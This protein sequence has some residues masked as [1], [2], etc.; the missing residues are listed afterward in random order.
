MI[1]NPIRK[2]F[3]IMEICEKRNIKFVMFGGL[4]YFDYFSINKQVENQQ[5]P[6]KCAISPAEVV[7][8]LTNNSIFS[9]VDKRKKHFIGWPMMKEIGGYS[10]DDMR[11]N[12]EEYFYG[13]EADELQGTD[14]LLDEASV[15][16]T[17]NIIM[18]ASLAEGVRNGR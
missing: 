14:M 6:E 13:V 1:L 9:E 3:A 11:Y 2:M 18:A 17:A 15:T 8:I 10:F 7:K 12:K 4:I 16:G 5:L